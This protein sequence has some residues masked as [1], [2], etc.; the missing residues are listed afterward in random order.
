M[1][2]FKIFSTVCILAASLT[3][4][5]PLNPPPAGGSAPAT[6]TSSQAPA[7]TPA[8]STAPAAGASAGASSNST[9]PASSNSKEGGAAF[10]AEDFTKAVTALGNAGAASEKDGFLKSLK[11]AKITSKREAAM[12]LAQVWHESGA[13]K[14]TKE[15]LCQENLAKCRVDYAPKGPGASTGKDYYG[16]GYI[17]LTHDYNYDAASK[18]LFGDDRLIKDPDQVAT[19]KELAWRTAAWFWGKNVHPDPGVQEGKFGASTKKINGALECGGPNEKAKKR[20]EFYTTIMK[21][22]GDTSPLVEAGCYN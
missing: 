11:D 19:D 22:I 14:Y 2:S 18:D 4:A 7:A 3:Q 12:F 9:A 5:L 10:T 1:L 8:A 16:R 15:I 6:P 20:F 21:A 13:L 17:Q